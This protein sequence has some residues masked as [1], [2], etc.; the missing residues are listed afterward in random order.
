MDFRVTMR[1]VKFD[2]RTIEKNPDV[3]LNACKDIGLAGNT[4]KTK[5]IEIGCHL[6]LIAYEDIRLGSN[7]HAKAKTFK[8]LDYLVTRQNAIQEEIKCR[9]K[10]GCYY[11]VQTLLSSR[12]L[13]NNLKIKIYKTGRCQ[14]CYMVVK[15][16]LLH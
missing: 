16:G 5:Y 12:L 4:A 15:H 14:L 11:S 1:M 9:L 3:L 6:C 8:N 10:A 13:S 7:S 2:N